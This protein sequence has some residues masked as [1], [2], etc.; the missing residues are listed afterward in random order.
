MEPL[1][2][3][4]GTSALDEV[5]APHAASEAENTSAARVPKSRDERKTIKQVIPS[6]R[7]GKDYRYGI[8]APAAETAN[9]YFELCGYSITP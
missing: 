3:P 8:L 5:L 2:A 4:A 1:E 6:V 7:R 9:D